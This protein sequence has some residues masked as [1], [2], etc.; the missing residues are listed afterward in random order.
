MK[1]TN[2]DDVPPFLRIHIARSSADA[3]R[4]TVPGHSAGL[5][6]MNTATIWTKTIRCGLIA[7]SISSSIVQET[8]SVEDFNIAWIRGRRAVMQRTSKGP[9]GFTVRNLQA[10]HL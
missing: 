6:R 7:V 2:N 1:L 3:T 9:S 8:A 4:T 10:L 5:P